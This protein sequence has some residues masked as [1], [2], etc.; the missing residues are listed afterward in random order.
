MRKAISN[1]LEYTVTAL[2]FSCPPMVSWDKR[3]KI[4]ILRRK[5]KSHSLWRPEAVM[6][7]LNREIPKSDDILFHS[8]T[9][10]AGEGVSPFTVFKLF[11]KFCDADQTLLLP[12][13]PV[14]KAGK[15][16]HL[17]YD[18]EP[19]PSSVGLIPEIA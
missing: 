11:E 10:G 17:K 1:L 7:C 5:I 2:Y 16:G 3:C 9:A 13:H 15:E 19:F 6:K 14:L 12:S 18:S 4:G 8:F